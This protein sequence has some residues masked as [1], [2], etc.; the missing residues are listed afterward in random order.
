M[1]AK[2]QPDS[3]VR[4]RWKDAL[5]WAIFAAILLEFGFNIMRGHSIWQRLDRLEFQIEQIERQ[6]ATRPGAR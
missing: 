2:P 6:T 1:N 5:L 4:S 3:N